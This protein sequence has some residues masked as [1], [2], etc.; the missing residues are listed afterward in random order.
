M[1]VFAAA[2]LAMALVCTSAGQAP[3]AVLGAAALA[4]GILVGLS[5]RLGAL[6]E[7]VPGLLLALMAVVLVTVLLG[8]AASSGIVV[9]PAAVPLAGLAVLGLDWRLV[10]R[11]RL[12]PFLSGLVVVVV[13]GTRTDETWAYPA[14]VVWFALA[15]GALWLLENDRRRS[16]DR[17]EPLAHAVGPP[18]EPHTGDV[19]RTIG[20]GL[21]IGLAAAF[22]LGNPSC[23]PHPKTPNPPVDKLPDL[24]NLPSG[25]ER[26][27]PGEVPPDRRLDGDAQ[28]RTFDIDEAGNRSFTDPATGERFTV[29]DEGG[30]DVVRGEDGRE[31]AQID[32]DGVVAGSGGAGSA[33]YRV[34]GQGRTYTEDASG[35]RYYLERSGGRTVLR[36]R[37]GKVV[38]EGRAGDDHLVIRDPDGSTLVPDPD[39]D[40]RI[41]VPGA[42]LSERTLGDGAGR[43][44]THEDGK[45]VITDADGDRRTYDTDAQGH[46]RVKVE[47][48]GRPTRSYSYDDSGP[49][50]V[51][52]EFDE[53]GKLLR[54]YRYDPNGVIVEP[55]GAVG[56]SSDP[57]ASSGSGSSGS[58]SSD[59]GSADP[60]DQKAEHDVPWGPI[61][62]GV[63][64]LAAVAALVWWLSRRP[65][66][67]GERPWAE[68][69]VRRIDDF[70]TAH[71][72][73]RA[74]ATTVVE[75]TRDLASSVAPDERLVEV[76]RELSVALFGRGGLGP[77]RQ[78][79][80]EAMLDAVI[81]AHPPPSWT[82][83]FHRKKDD[84][85][86]AAAAG[87]ADP[88]RSGTPVA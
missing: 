16:L 34:D 35:N 29:T 42:G 70:G 36:D 24:G 21:V 43:T 62:L 64:A 87:G 65:G 44:V 23:S 3:Y 25:G 6:A 81:E 12:V 4:V 15:I 28:E 60:P 30:R 69:Q 85:A 45:T 57:G 7:R 18:E 48:N 73:P 38:A 88:D 46:P 49:Y 13:V 37:D 61:G 82:D 22:L 32:P 19:L 54:R 53:D 50:T 75:H 14:A 33:R 83:R 31:V 8:V 10:A 17:P 68:A 11:L 80:V 84:A 27:Q 39:G 67:E 79:E 71:G 5:T 86:P 47:E 20:V 40:G 58:G 41:P 76:G 74:R 59:P 78:A 55:G 9:P 26:A 1:A 72:R 63:L 51:V 66:P 77:D 56:S 2:V 52:S